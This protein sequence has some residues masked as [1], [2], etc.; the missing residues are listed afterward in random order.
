MSASAPGHVARKTSSWQPKPVHFSRVE[1]EQTIAE[2]KNLSK[3]ENQ[4]ETNYALVCQIVLGEHAEAF[5]AFMDRS[6][7]FT[8]TEYRLLFN[9]IPWLPPEKR[10]SVFLKAAENVGSDE[11]QYL[12]SQYS[13]VRNPESA[14]PIWEI[15]KN[16]NF[17][18]SSLYRALLSVNFANNVSHYSDMEPD[19]VMPDLIT[20][21]KQKSQT[22]AQS[23][24]PTQQKLA[25]LMVNKV[26]LAAGK[27]LAEQLL[28]T[29]A[30][31][32]VKELAFRVTLVA[33]KSTKRDRWGD[34]IESNDRSHAVEKLKTDDAQRFKTTLRYLALGNDVLNSDNGIY[35]V[36]N[37]YS[38]SYGSSDV[39]VRIPKPPKGMTLEHLKSEELETLGDEEVLALLAYFKSLLDPKTDLKPLV[40]YWENDD[41]DEDIAKMVYQAVAA[42]SNDDLIPAVESIYDSHGKDSDHYA[43]ELYWT[44]RVMS[45]KKAL[46]LRKRIR[47]EIGMST[48]ENY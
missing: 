21:V 11:G 29:G 12:L 37:Y 5:D 27:E 23:D 3:S 43:A 41:T 31:E 48:L 44:I 28:E 42:T 20:L 13:K 35:L 16:D 26:D 36:E 18:L 9:L 4:D 24:N 25:L 45:G 34:I 8:E 33:P 40:E 10:T 39:K 22:Y 15:A 17:K 19:S 14:E 6:E 30:D 38:Y 32:D 46:A 47:D 2:I 1:F 7:S